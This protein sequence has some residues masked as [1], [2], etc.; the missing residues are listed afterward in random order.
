MDMRFIEGAAKIEQDY[1]YFPTFHD[2][3]I[4]EI[5]IVPGRI[6]IVVKMNTFPKA[7]MKNSN[8]K[9][10]NPMGVCCHKVIEEAINKGLAMK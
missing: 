3:D 10:N 4:K 5:R 2:D 9:V 6:E 1:G 8:C 7:L